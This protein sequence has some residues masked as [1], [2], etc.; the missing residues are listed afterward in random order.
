MYDNLMILC[1][2]KILT[3]VR[4]YTPHTSKRWSKR[5]EN[6]HKNMNESDDLAHTHF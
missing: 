6:A 5:P 1:P 3:F 4:L 2:F